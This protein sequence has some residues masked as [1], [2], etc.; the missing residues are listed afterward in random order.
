MSSPADKFWEAVLHWWRD[1]SE[2][3]VEFSGR[4][5]PAKSYTARVVD[6]VE[7]MITF[8]DVETGE[9]RTVN[10]VGGE[11]RFY[12]YERMD[13]R[14]AFAVKWQDGPESVDCILTGLRLEISLIDLMKNDCLP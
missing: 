10:F 2:I 11:V 6:V 12:R 13:S 14:N 8:R 3:E 9:K 4:R 5:Q 7:E 1:H